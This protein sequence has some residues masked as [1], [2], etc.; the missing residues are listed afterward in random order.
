MRVQ[1][2]GLRKLMGMLIVSASDK[3]RVQEEWAC[4]Q[5]FMSEYM[6]GDHRA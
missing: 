4:R 6:D 5:Y 2:L 1:Q 3:E